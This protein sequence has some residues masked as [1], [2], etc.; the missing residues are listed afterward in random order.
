M[1]SLLGDFAAAV[2]RHP[3]RVAIV[4]GTGRETSFAQ[5]QA[6]A[7]ALARL[8]RARGVQRGA[9]VLLAMPLNADLYASLAA[10][11]S[12]GATVVLP[13]PA[14][15]LAGL[16]HAARTSGA[17]LFCSAGAYRAL[18]YLLPSLW[19][20]RHITPPGEPR[21]E[22]VQETA[23]VTPPMPADIALISF[24]SGTSGAP[25]AIPRSHGFLNAQHQAIA[26]L[27]HSAEEERDLVAF[28]VFVLINIASGRTS[29]LPNWRMSRLAALEPAAMADWMQRQQVTRALIPPSLCE[30]LSQAPVP[31]SLRRVFTGGGPVF[32]DLLARMAKAKPDLTTVCVYGSTEAEPIAHLNAAEITAGDRARMMGGQGLLVG[33]PV[34]DL[35]LR[36]RAD[37]IQVAGAH[38]NGGY[39]DPR[40]DIDTK[41]REGD[42]IWHRT[43]DAGA[44]DGAGRLWLLGRIG[45]QV[46]MPEGPLYP[47]SVEVAAHGWA[48]V[49]QCAF[50]QAVEGPTLVIA[51][52]ARHLPD[53][54]R[55]AR[56]MGISRLRHLD[57]IPM[58]RRHAS[59]VDRAALMARLR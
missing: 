54:Q 11:W 12:L 33:P 39:L 48:G 31:A 36:L 27:L 9:R 25:K 10:L 5:L 43:G 57:K 22:T 18:R 26:P 45:T 29:V 46:A 8:W 17:T 20:L 2:A 56:A 21:S 47:F 52:A 15:G 38:V 30:K 28:P 53:W 44:L 16:R 1:V 42:V 7:E 58:D 3:Q 55:N 51:G 40:Q 32:P 35:R 19:P 37:E 6:R 14:M 24:T 41:I 49:R 59:K 23:E 34:P 4:D 50:V 13:E